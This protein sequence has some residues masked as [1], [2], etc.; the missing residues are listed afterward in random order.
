MSDPRPG[1]FGGAPEERD[2]ATVE[3]AD[4]GMIALHAKPVRAAAPG[5]LGC[6]EIVPFSADADGADIAYA[7]SLASSAPL[8]HAKLSRAEALRA[9]A[10][11]CAAIAEMH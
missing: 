2:G 11:A 8:P 6:A 3:R 4:A 7:R 5:R 1:P 9:I 10:D